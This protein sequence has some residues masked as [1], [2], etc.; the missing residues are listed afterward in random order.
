VEPDGLEE[1][2]IARIAERAEH[3]DRE[4]QRVA[5]LGLLE[6]LSSRRRNLDRGAGE[7]GV[8]LQHRLEAVD[9]GMDERDERGI[10]DDAHD[11]LLERA[12]FFDAG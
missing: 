7:R 11:G 9:D 4:L 2:A 5:L 10:S 6:K 8:V 12:H 1:I 3:R